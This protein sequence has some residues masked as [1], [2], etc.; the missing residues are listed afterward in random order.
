MLDVEH[1]EG[2]SMCEPQVLPNLHYDL[3][4]TGYAERW[5]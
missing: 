1:N 5:S 4:T 2:A 3:R